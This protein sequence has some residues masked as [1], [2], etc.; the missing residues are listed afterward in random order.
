MD[1]QVDN[2][3]E[4]LFQRGLSLAQRGQYEDAVA[5]FQE[6]LRLKPESASAH[7]N[8]GNLF[9][10]LGRLDEAVGSFRHA[11]RYKPDFVS[12]HSNLGEALRRQGHHGEAAACFRD[13]LA[14]DPRH[15]HA[16]NNLAMALQAQ[17]KLDLALESYRQA[18]RCMPGYT[19]A[20]CHLGAALLEQGSLEEA[21]ANLSKAIELKPDYVDAIFNRGLVRWKQGRTDEALA[22]YQQALRINPDHALTHLHLGTL[23]ADTGQL[24][25]AEASLRRALGVKP[26]FVDALYNLAIVLLKQA[27]FPEALAQ[28]EEVLR[29]QPD[30]AAARRNLANIL[31]EH[32]RMEEALAAY[33]TALNCN[34]EAADLHSCVLLISQYLP[35]SDARTMRNE[36]ARWNQKHAEPLKALIRPHPNSPDPERRLRI[37]YVS[38][39]FRFHVDSFFTVPLLSNH[40]HKLYEIVCY[41]DVAQPDP[42]TERLRS[43]ADVWRRTLGLSDAEVAEL[44]R[45]DQIDILVDLEMHSAG[46]RLLVFARKPAPVQV[47]WLA[48]PGTTGLSAIDYRLT[49]PYLDPPGL[50]DDFYSEETIRLPETFWCYDPL[51]DQPSVNSLPALENGIITFGCLNNFCKVNERCLALWA[52]ALREVQPSRLLLRA[53]GSQAR[54]RVLTILEREGIA[55]SRIEFVDTLPRHEYLPLYHRIDLCLDPIP[56]NGHTTSLDAFWM[57]VPTVTLVGNTVVG[58]AGWSQLCNLG[59]PELAAQAPEQYVALAALLAED[60]PRLQGLRSTLRQRMQQSPLMDAKRFARHMEQAFR[61]M[62]RNWCRGQSQC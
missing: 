60:L 35:G 5:S 45:S 17:G 37:G 16:H 50:F 49:D 23:L 55:E 4:A 28:Y 22:Q 33:R 18:L 34:P 29:L 10:E 47:A 7:N 59:F 38:P 51:V 57:G 41:A 14:I 9:V 48:Y 6:A 15:A 62:W 39:D 42:V 46:N 21:A 11:L 13:A 54:N 26:D 24:V 43:Y 40:D 3:F 44:V 36:C 20:Y 1:S 30:H 58:R 53:P 31:W 27:K 25:E 52:G 19:E 32:G 56:Y 12:A 8:L 61:H 2:P